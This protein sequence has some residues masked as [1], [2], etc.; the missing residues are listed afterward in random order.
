MKSL[1]ILKLDNF[2][3][4]ILVIES[5]S[6]LFDLEP[7]KAIPKLNKAIICSLVALL[8][9]SEFVQDIITLYRRSTDLLLYYSTIL[10]IISYGIYLDQVIPE[11]DIGKILIFTGVSS[12]P[13]INQFIRHN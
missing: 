4:G 6:I 8:L 13:F 9:F 2:H 12:I 11:T 7:S 1:T 10:I 5:F 3:K